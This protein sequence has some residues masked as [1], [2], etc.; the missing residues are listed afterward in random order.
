MVARHSTCGASDGWGTP[1]GHAWGAGG[2]SAMHAVFRSIALQLRQSRSIFAG[3]R[4]VL[5]VASCRVGFRLLL[6]GTPLQNNL[7]ELFTLMHF[8]EPQKFA[9]MEGFAAQLE[10]LGEEQ[11]VRRCLLRLSVHFRA[12]LA[13][14]HCFS[15]LLMEEHDVRY[16]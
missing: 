15:V 8:L 13:R 12:Q 1:K 7:G 2:V 14:S 11:Q 5:G 9:S 4:V 3:N 16:P 10:D 6:T